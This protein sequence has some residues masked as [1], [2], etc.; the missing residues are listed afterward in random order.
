MFEA[1]IEYYVGGDRTHTML[2]L[3]VGYP[4]WIRQ[5]ARYGQGRSVFHLGTLTKVTPT[6]QCTV[7]L[8]DGSTVRF[9]PNTHR[10]TEYEQIGRGRYDDS[11]HISCNEERSEIETVTKRMAATAEAI[12][13]AR[14][15]LS[16]IIKGAEY[17]PHSGVGNQRLVDV[18]QKA[19]W[20]EQAEALVEAMR[21]LPVGG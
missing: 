15:A 4:V 18:N 2:P 20:I 3:D 13:V 9:K 14:E 1:R 19:K 6:M 12:S 7:T 21:A 16:V 10:A 5:I 11:Y 8:K 17:W